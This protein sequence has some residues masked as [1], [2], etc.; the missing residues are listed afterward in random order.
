MSRLLRP[1][2]AGPT[3]ARPRRALLCEC[4]R[5]YAHA[6]TWWAGK[7][8]VA[9]W[10][11]PAG[12]AAAAVEALKGG[13][14]TLYYSLDV[15]GAAHITMIDTESAIDTPEIDDAELA[16]LKADLAA[17]D[18]PAARD[19]QPWL[20]TAGHRPLYCSNPGNKVQCTTYATWLRGAAEGVLNGAHVDMHLQAHEHDMEVSWPTLN[21]TVVARNYTN[22]TAPVY[23]V[24]G[25]AGNRE[26]NGGAGGPGF[27]WSAWH[28]AA[29]GYGRV[30]IA[31]PKALTYDFVYSANRTVAHSVTIERS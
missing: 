7:P 23:V 31:G 1:R 20:L 6:Q 2:R 12:G 19:K 27:H 13:S 30:S 18:T 26:G 21:N 15:A 4:A 9:R 5:T 28:S 22:P 17:A 8:A 16:W 11:Q 3:R 29:Y 10:Y 25:A 14:S 24:Q